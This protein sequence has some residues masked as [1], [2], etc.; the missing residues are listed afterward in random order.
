M[1]VTTA[2]TTLALALLI[3]SPALG[4]TFDGRIGFRPDHVFNGTPIPGSPEILTSG[5]P[6]ARQALFGGFA[7]QGFTSRGTFNFLG[8]ITVSDPIGAATLS[9]PAT[10]LRSPYNFGSVISLSPDGREI[11]FDANRGAGQVN[12]PW[13]VG[14]PRPDETY[15]YPATAGG[16]DAYFPGIRFFFNVNNF[17]EPRAITLTVTGSMQVIDRWFFLGGEEGETADLLPG[18]FIQDA[19]SASYIFIVDVPAPAGLGALA[20]GGLLA[21]RRRR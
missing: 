17:V 13:P 16:P 8:T 5:A 15:T 20:L 19:V 12:V 14:E 10:S 1:N 11:S 3:G 7:A 6:Q 21:A 9:L 4:Q 18:G 2:T